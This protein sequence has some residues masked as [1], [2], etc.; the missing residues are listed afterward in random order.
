[1]E[2]YT[3]LA[4][5]G[6][7]IVLVLSIIAAALGYM[8]RIILA[9]NLTVEEFGLFYSVFA[10]LSFVG[11]FKSLGFDKALIRFI[12]DFLS[13]N[14]PG[15]IKSGIVYAAIIQV[16]SNSL[17]I[18]V[19][20][21]LADFLAIHYFKAAQ[22]AFILKFMAIAFFADSFAVTIKYVFQ[23]FRKMVYFSM[24]DFVRMLLLIAVILLGLNLG[25]G[26]TAPVIAHMIA[27]LVLIIVFG[28]ILVRKVFPGFFSSELV[29]DMVLAKRMLRYG[30]FIILG[31]VG[32]IIMG[33]LDIAMITYFSGLTAVALYSA[34]LP[35]TRILSYIPDAM[36]TV[37]F[38]LTAELWAKR[39][40][41]ILQEGIESLYKYS[42]III[43]PLALIMLTF[44]D[45]IINVFF[46]K[47]YA[48]ATIAMQI[49][50]IGMVFTAINKVCN[51]FFMGIGKP[52]ISS[53]IVY[54]AAIFNF[55][56]NLILIPV[57]G[58]VGAAITTSISFFIMAGMGLR[59]IRRF[60]PVR[61][62][63]VIWG[64]TLGAGMA[65]VLSILLLKKYIIMNVWMEAALVLLASGFVYTASLFILKV[66]T[67]REIKG[68]YRR[69]LK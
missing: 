37:L 25:Y 56:G 47:D 58:I 64:K 32:V 39:K 24:V 4:V 9:R 46:G 57:I 6:A 52:E 40:F 69:I 16:I 53:R 11:I 38:P 63:L 28:F 30:S 15:L 44:A 14:Q 36:I 51:N 59:N 49:L 2:S 8:I 31:S 41:G 18:L 17:M 35:T 19:V 20:Y 45:I 22:A 7:S 3:K 55:I 12:P 61:L 33:T 54:T 48:S 21:L 67:L 60:I 1:M 26:I 10:F 68:L 34:A 62:P 66:L 27:P 43:L 5:R 65:M 29:Y 13:K 42:T 23:A 50:S